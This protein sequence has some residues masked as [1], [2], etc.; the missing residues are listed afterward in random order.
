MHISIVTYILA[1]CLLL[2]IAGCSSIFLRKLRFPYTIGLVIVGL[3]IAMIINRSPQLSSDINI[4]I[5]H[6]IIYYILIPV[7][8]FDASVNMDSRLL[9]RNIVPVIILAVPGL[10]ISLLIVGVIM[11]VSTPLAIGS[12]MLF[13][14]LISA[15]DPV[16]VIALFKEIG[17]P[18]RLTM[19]VDGES[20]FN[21]ATA[22]VA[23][24]IVLAIIVTGT[25]FTF[26]TAFGSIFEF[27][28]VFLGGVVVGIIIGYIAAKI[29]SIS[30]KDPMVVLVMSTVLAFSSFAIAD[31]F[32][33]VS[34][35]MAVLAAG[36]TVNYYNTTRLNIEAKEYL[37]KF[38][39]Y[40][41]FMA[42]SFIFI[43]L[44]IVEWRMFDE[45]RNTDHLIFYII[46]AIL[47]VIISRA[48]V[49]YG[50]IPIIKLLPKQRKISWQY[51]TIIFWG[52]LRGAVPLAL[53]FSLSSAIP[54][55][56]LIVQLTLAIVLFTIIIQGISTKFLMKIFGLNKISIFE[57]LLLLQAK[58]QVLLKS[59]EF[60]KNVSKNNYANSSL[61]DELLASYDKDG[62]V[63]VQKI[64]EIQ[65]NPDFTPD[66]L[67]KVLWLEAISIERH[68]YKK[69]IDRKMISTM[70][71][72][73]LDIRT[74]FQ[75][76]QIKDGQ[77]PDI[78]FKFSPPLLKLK[79]K[80][81]HLLE[82]YLHYKSSLIK[83][84][85]L[86]DIQIE[87]E[88]M[89]SAVTASTRVS[90]ELDSLPLLYTNQKEILD[91]C[92]DYYRKRTELAVQERETLSKYISMLKLQ[93]HY[94]SIA[95]LS[96]QMEGVEELHERGLIPANI[97]LILQE[98]LSSRTVK[99]N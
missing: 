65:D 90:A 49:V 87:Y 5:F 51:Q 75:I 1:V 26:L 27:T 63:T 72:R 20:L 2:F 55:N 10:L 59:T 41:S 77:I 50:L 31:H 18:K 56:T 84:M 89:Y 86:R 69:L 66:V 12:A 61:I 93:N 60:L 71:F 8:I 17:A 7:L 97:A 33:E 13:G 44:G 6:Q 30:A 82:N 67:R 24:N 21:D 45:V 48:V 28:R 15:T 54:G 91:E 80:I 46:A 76:E 94:L 96:E 29:M 81:F 38:W 53:A 16:A 23:F 62:E 52:G 79:K 70:V 68:I 40:A 42:N 78:Y 35:V 34:G 88:F 22:I 14:A 19:L 3:I 37:I 98:E 58:L 57:T 39:E 25:Q 4:V 36:M 92:K 43:V 74:D 73:A 64:I 83:R 99:E 85:K 47:A 11:Y 32:L 9:M 95:A